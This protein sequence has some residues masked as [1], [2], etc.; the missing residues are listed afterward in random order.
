V[1]LF[2]NQIADI[3]TSEESDQQPGSI[4]ETDFFQH[5]WRKQ[6]YL[7][8][9]ACSGSL[10]TLVSCSSEIQLLDLASN[11]IVESRMVSR[12]YELRLG[13]F[14]L[15]AI[16]ENQL[17]MIQGLE[18]HLGEINQLLLD[19]FPFMPRW[20]IE[21]VMAT[22][23]NAGANCGAHFDHYDVFLL[24]VRGSKDWQLDG[25]GHSEHH[26]DHEADIRLLQKFEQTSGKLAEPGDVLY[27]PPG[28]GHLGIA[29]DESITLSIGIRNPTMAELISHLA[30]M[31]IDGTDLTSTLDDQ[32]QTPS[33][34]ITDLDIQHLQARLADT[35]L[36][37]T[38][39]ARWYGSYMT[40]PREP[41]LVPTGNAITGKEVSGLLSRHVQL[42]CTLPTRITYHHGEVGLTVFV[43]GETISADPAVLPWLQHLCA[44]RQVSS[45]LIPQED[46]NIDLC[47]I[48][49]NNG[50]IETVE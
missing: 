38:L 1:P 4:S 31:L 22:I 14:D 33:G 15:A 18:Q 23:G 43:N 34:C 39:I 5:Y 20:R 11:D 21:D 26:L 25:G 19:E 7:F 27:I 46:Y 36:D 47:K 41:E 9:G 40:E 6:S 17:L 28:M 10:D 45:C 30:D 48:L 32:L 24:Q 12:D 49:F 16:P 13:P 50:A 37:P 35:I 3:K 44:H 2:S 8:R 42:V 29:S